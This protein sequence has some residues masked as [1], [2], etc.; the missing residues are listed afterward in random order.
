MPDGRTHHAIWKKAWP[1]AI[2]VSAAAVT[3]TRDPIL[4]ASIPIGYFLGRY[5]SPDLDLVGINDDEARAMRELKIFG[6][7]FA[8]YFLVYAYLMR[9]VGIGRKGHRNFFSHF[10]IVS[11][12]IR[13]AWVLAIPAAVIWW[14]RIE[15]QT[16]WWITLVGIFSGLTLADT[17]HWFADVTEHK[18]RKVWKSVFSHN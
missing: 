8:A 13:L 6:A 5:L 15:P 14:Y 16:W 3:L 4:A 2:L 12:A 11:T 17:M 9:F 18:L 7:F 1:A 10:P